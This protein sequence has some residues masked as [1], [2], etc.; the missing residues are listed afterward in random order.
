MNPTAYSLPLRIF[1]Q[2]SNQI[3]YPP[4]NIFPII[5][6][7]FEWKFIPEFPAQSVD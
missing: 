1:P 2:L 3:A 6:G 5:L 7:L 4:G